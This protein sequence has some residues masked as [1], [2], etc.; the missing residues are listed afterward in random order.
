MLQVA[1]LT[2]L[3]PCL[4]LALGLGLTACSAPDAQTRTSQALAQE[5]FKPAYA[6]WSKDSQ[7]LT[8]SAQALCAGMEDLPQARQA[9]IRAQTAWAALQPLQLGMISEG[10]RSWQVQFWP[11]KKN[12]VARQVKA[13]LERT[14]KP[15]Q[16]ELDQASV[17]LQ[18]LTAYEYLL[19]DPAID[20]SKDADKS[21][22]CSLLQAIAQHQKSLADEVFEDW[23]AADGI[24]SQLESFPN[25]RYADAHEAIA[26][27]L[28]AQ[29]TGLDVMKKKL[30]TPLG[31]NSKGQPQPYQAD[32]W[33]SGASLSNLAAGLNSAQRVWQGKTNNGLRSL[34]DASQQPLAKQIDQAYADSQQRLETLQ[35]PLGEML[36]SQNGR[37]LLIELYD[38]LLQLQRLYAGELATALNVQLGFNA[39]DGD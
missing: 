32:A 27:V 14:P 8:G 36:P 3:A 13:L 15:S 10:N 12:L 26:A 1:R 23:E 11:D 19:F 18:G 17:V 6:T 30:G 21:R 24:A 38:S 31:L 35:Q 33:R 39:H 5:V 28:G 29:V 16:S 7:H 25:P 34:L 9:F 20:L 4:G 22:Y 37:T 2:L